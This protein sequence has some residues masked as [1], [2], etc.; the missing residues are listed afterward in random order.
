MWM[1]WIT[2]PNVQAQVAE[3]F[4]EAP[5]NLKACALTTDKD[6]CDDLPREGRGVLQADLVLG[7]PAGRLPRRA[8]RHQVRAVLELVEGLERRSATLTAAVRSGRGR[9][10]GHRPPAPEDLWSPPWTPPP[11]RSARADARRRRLSAVLFRHA[12]VRLAGA[13]HACR[14]CGW[15]LDLL[16]RALL[17][18]VH[19][20]LHVDEFTNE[21]V[22]TFTLAELRGRL[23][24]A[25]STCGRRCGP[26]GSPRR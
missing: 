2:T 21:V 9:V 6:H 22:H 3:W 24:R 18:A 26:W 7:D 13:A 4:G 10:P 25:R 1:N 17:A 16:R 15:S 12:R 19:G 14:C 20:V 11:H 23:H 5:A 8:H